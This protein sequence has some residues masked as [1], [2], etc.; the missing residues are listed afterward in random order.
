MLRLCFI[1][2]LSLAQIGGLRGSHVCV[3]NSD[4][5]IVIAYGRIASQASLCAT[6]LLAFIQERSQWSVFNTGTC[7]LRVT[8]MWH[9]GASSTIARHTSQNDL[10]GCNLSGS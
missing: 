9:C 1:F 3:H 10:R 4:Y 5:L 2:G 8:R 7:S 6:G